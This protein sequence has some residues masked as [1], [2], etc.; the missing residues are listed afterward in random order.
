MY[1]QRKL[2]ITVGL[3]LALGALPSW[4][5]AEDAPQVEQPQNSTEDSPKGEIIHRY[6]GSER[7]RAPRVMV[8]VLGGSVGAL[9]GTTVGF[10]AV[11]P[12]AASICQES[13]NHP[14]WATAAGTGAVIGM[15]LGVYAGGSLVHG[16]GS[17]WLTLGGGVAGV[18]FSGWG[19]TRLVDFDMDYLPLFA[20]PPVLGAILGFEL[21]HDRHSARWAGAS[22]VRVMPVLAVGR[23]GGVLGGLAGRF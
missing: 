12:F 11:L 6:T 9:A 14:I 2:G 1:G 4:A 21:S 23:D 17:F 20:L 5:G 15:S 8:E 16:E 13:C 18:A 7:P 19:L 3:I 10:L 22:D